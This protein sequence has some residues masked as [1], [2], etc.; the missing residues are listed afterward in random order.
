MPLTQPGCLPF[1]L[2]LSAGLHLHMGCLPVLSPPSPL[3]LRNDTCLLENTIT[4]TNYLPQSDFSQAGVRGDNGVSPE[5]R[6]ANYPPS[7]SVK[8]PPD[9]SAASPDED[10][11]RN[12][13][14]C[15][16]TFFLKLQK[17][18]SVIRNKP[19][20]SHSIKLCNSSAILASTLKAATGR[21]HGVNESWD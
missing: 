3:C 16:Q 12:S 13:R 15:C 9:S 1:Y 20:K 17:F 21:R 7:M 19:R 10:K 8:I 14:C 4:S 5:Y 6:A 18:L 2:P 11:L